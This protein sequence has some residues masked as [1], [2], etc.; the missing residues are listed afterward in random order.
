MDNLKDTLELNTNMEYLVPTSCCRRE[1]NMCPFFV[2]GGRE[3]VF[4]LHLETKNVCPTFHR[5]QIGI[6]N[7][8]SYFREVFG[9][10][11]YTELKKLDLY[12]SCRPEVGKTVRL[13]PLYREV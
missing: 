11:G 12:R 6:G 13:R 4:S 10:P 5:T 7:P 9:L 3:Q 8:Y 1:V 2:E